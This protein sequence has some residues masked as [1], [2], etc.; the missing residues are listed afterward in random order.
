MFR[1]EP[2]RSRVPHGVIEV[3]LPATDAGVAFQFGVVL[4]AGAT[5]IVATR[6]NRDVRILAI[7]LAVLLVALM[8]ARA[9]H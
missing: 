5:G 9:I 6:R 1:H 7:G 3:L 2:G 8:A 4:V